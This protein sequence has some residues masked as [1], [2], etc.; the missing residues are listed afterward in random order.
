MVLEEARDA[1]A[2]EIVHEVTSTSPNDV[3]TNV[4]RVR[5]W[6]AQWQ[7]SVGVCAWLCVCQRGVNGDLGVGG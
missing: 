3:Q 5:A 1:Y 4:E 2:P 6:V 7:V